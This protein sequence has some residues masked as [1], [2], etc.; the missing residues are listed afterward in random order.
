MFI[1]IVNVKFSSK[2][3][4]D[5]MNALAKHELINILYGIISIEVVRITELH[6]IVINKFNSKE[7]AEKSKELVI[8]KLKS[9]SNIKVEIYEGDRS[10][11]IEKS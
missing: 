9:N 3:E 1:R 5:A 2:I 11:I 4:A 8:N 7:C 6:S 10:F